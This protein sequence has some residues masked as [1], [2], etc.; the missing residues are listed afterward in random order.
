MPPTTALKDRS[1]YH[2]HQVFHRAARRVR[3]RHRVEQSVIVPSV[4]RIRRRIDGDGDGRGLVGARCS[5]VHG[6]GVHTSAHRSGIDHATDH[7]AEDRSTHHRH[8]VFH[9]AARRAKRQ[10]R[11]EQSV[12]VPSVS[13]I[14]RR[15]DRDGHRGGLIGARRGA[16]NGVDI[17][18][19]AHRCGVDHA[20]DHRR[21]AAPRTTCI[22]RSAEL[23][24]ERGGGIRVN[25]A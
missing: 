7:G 11:C 19:S 22:R 4:S 12:I 1:T 25:R 6:V 10:H 24:E 2:Q 21:S 8:R 5:A 13:W 16:G 18:P 15:V 17:D 3:Q 20:T 14:R 23:R 9:Q